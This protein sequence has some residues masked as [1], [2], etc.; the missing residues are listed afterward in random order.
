MQRIAYGATLHHT[1]RPGGTGAPANY[2]ASTSMTTGALTP[3]PLA[4][5]ALRTMGMVFVPAFR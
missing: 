5:P 1:F 3:V 2:L 4:G